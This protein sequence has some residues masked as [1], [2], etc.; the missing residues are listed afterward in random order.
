MKLT[1]HAVGHHA[2]VRL[3]LGPAPRVTADEGSLGQVFV[4]LLLNAAE[5]IGD[6]HADDNEIVVSTGTDAAGNAVVE[7]KDTGPGIPPAV[8]PMLFDPFFTTKPVG[9]GMG[10][11]LAICYSIVGDAGGQI[12]AENAPP[13]GALFRITLP[14]AGMAEEPVGAITSSPSA[15][16]RR[17]RV[18]IVDDE[19]HVARVMER[20]LRASHD[21]TV[22]T[23]GQEA[24]A[25]VDRGE[26]FDVVLCDVM[27]P[28]TSGMDVYAAL[29]ARHPAQAERVIFTTGG[30]FSDQAKV[31][32]ASVPNA[33][34][35]KPFSAEL[36]RALVQERLDGPPKGE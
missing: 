27:M 23:G 25:H 31:F 11:G 1:A 36:L 3:E 28:N 18:L 29:R 22:C 9:A 32:L 8:L 21:V 20:I 5:A 34:V 26:H 12:A 30:A 33:Q 10:L 7:V 6:G 16:A 4:N 15:L 2:R 13:F 19:P 17:G 14:P 35:N 24:L